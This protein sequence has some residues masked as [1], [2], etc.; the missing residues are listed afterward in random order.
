[1]KIKI[2]PISYDSSYDH[3]GDLEE[4]LDFYT[5][6]FEWVEV[7][8][9]QLQTIIENRYEFLN[10][11]KKNVKEIRCADDIIILQDIPE[12][13]QE[14]VQVSVKSLIEEMNEKARKK[15]EAAKKRAEAKRKREEKKRLNKEAEEKKLL[16][17]LQKKYADEK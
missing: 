5:T 11:L 14:R 16:E 3:Y 15:E 1:M 13:T 12:V 7:T 2:I 8:L 17:E 6:D 4:N 10:S 9:N